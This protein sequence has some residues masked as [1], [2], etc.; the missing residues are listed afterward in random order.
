MAF[1]FSEE[2]EL[3][4]PLRSWNYQWNSWMCMHRNRWFNQFNTIHQSLPYM[5]WFSTQMF[6]PESLPW[7]E[8]VRTRW[9][10]KIVIDNGKADWY[11]PVSK[12][13]SHPYPYYCHKRAYMLMVSPW[14]PCH[15][16]PPCLSGQSDPH[17]QKWPAGFYKR[18]ILLLDG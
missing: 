6:F 17:Q 4:D 7:K 10:W 9:Y 14:Y 13:D 18:I 1:L 11:V 12:T 3:Y 5:I 15:R 16:V 8:I 2:W